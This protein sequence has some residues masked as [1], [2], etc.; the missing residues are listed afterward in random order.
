ME[1]LE[2]YGQG[3]NCSY[4]RR[5]YYHNSFLIANPREAWVLETA[6]DYWA[7]KRVEGVRRISN[8]L[9]IERGWDLAHPEF[10]DHAVEMG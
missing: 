5:L 1:L 10:I 2:K 7:A 9:T 8:V 3:G 6:G 4:T